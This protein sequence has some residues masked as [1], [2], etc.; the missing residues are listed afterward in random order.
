[1]PRLIVLK[2][3]IPSHCILIPYCTFNIHFHLFYLTLMITVCFYLNSQEKNFHRDFFQKK[4]TNYH[5]SSVNR[6]QRYSSHTY[7]KRLFQNY[8]KMNITSSINP[9]FGLKPKN[10]LIQHERWWREGRK[11]V[12]SPFSISL[13][14]KPERKEIGSR[15]WGRKVFLS[16][17]AKRGGLAVSER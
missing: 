8:T 10:D 2:V 13:I 17:L 15:E 11:E 6:P 5:K 16:M 7:I 9:Q 1:M 4:S 12:L 14:L 3:E